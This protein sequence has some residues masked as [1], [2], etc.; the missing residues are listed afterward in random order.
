MLLLGWR[1]AKVASRRRLHGTGRAGGERGGVSC[2]KLVYG[3]L[4]EGESQGRRKQC[5]LVHRCALASQAVASCKFRGKTSVI[6]PGAAR[7]QK[8][9]L[10]GTIQRA[11]ASTTS[12]QQ[13]KPVA[14]PPFPQG[15]PPTTTILPKPPTPPVEVITNELRCIGPDGLKQVRHRAKHQPIPGTHKV[16][17]GGQVVLQGAGGKKAAPV[18]T[19]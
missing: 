16:G 11:G 17:Q 14:V 3:L 12:G 8:I 7:H 6:G 4:A 9:R 2:C 15:T 13:D 10:L 1:V 19:E 5:L 18:G